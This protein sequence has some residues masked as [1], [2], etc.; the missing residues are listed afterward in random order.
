MD[1]GIQRIIYYYYTN[2]YTYVHVHVLC[3]NFYLM[4]FKCAHTLC[5]SPAVGDYV[6]EDEV[7][8]EIE[9]DKVSQLHGFLIIWCT[10]RIQYA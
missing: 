9:T 6:S 5:M 2:L 3:V 10:L 1:K 7:L 4:L 8:A